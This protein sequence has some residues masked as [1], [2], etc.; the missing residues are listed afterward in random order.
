PKFFL[1][2]SQ[3][4]KLIAQLDQESLPIRKTLL[5]AE[6]AK[7]RTFIELG[8]EKS[9][10]GAIDW[11]T[12]FGERSWIFGADS[13]LRDVLKRPNEQGSDEPM[14]PVEATWSF[15]SHGHFV[16]M[17]RAYWLTGWESL[18][19][20]FI[21][22]IVDWLER[23]P[24]LYGINWIDPSSI[25]ARTINWMLAFNLFS[26]SDQ[27]QA[28][29]MGRI[30]RGLVTHGA[31]MADILEQPD[32]ALPPQDLLATAAALNCLAM[33]LPE[34]KAAQRWYNLSAEQ[35]S[36]RAWETMGRDGLHLSGSA[37]KQ[38]EMLEWLLLPE[39][40][41]RLNGLPSPRGLREATETACEADSTGPTGCGS[42]THRGVHLRGP[43]RGG[44][45]SLPS[46]PSPG[47]RGLPK[48][49]LSSWSRNAGRTL[50]VVGIS[51]SKSLSGNGSRG[52]WELNQSL[53]H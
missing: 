45:S 2:P 48:R 51:S 32:D 3:K 5:L 46:P 38:R 17:G 30:L 36:K 24:A 37:A 19:A 9:F 25:S 50:V 28:E 8:I 44:N 29:V 41:H 47:F 52:Q 27:M 15:N 16:D 14:G 7:N 13:D 33:Y 10:P 43:T 20:E 34:L 53:F 4:D 42:G 40:L 49:R 26:M 35:L 1:P 6:E 22:Q 18:V 23:N 11:F 21:V 39:V 12:D 31:V